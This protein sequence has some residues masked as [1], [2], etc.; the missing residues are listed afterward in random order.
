MPIYPF[1]CTACEYP[2]E[3]LAE[4]KD[5]NKEKYCPHCGS[6]MRRAMEEQT[7]HMRGDIEA[8]F[9]ESLGEYV[10]SRRELREKLAYANAYCPDLMHGSEP[11]AG[12]LTSEERAIEENRSAQPKKTIFERRQEPGWDEVGVMRDDMLEVEGKADYKAFMSEVKERNAARG[13]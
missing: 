10:G 9:D 7:V 2:E 6:L 5:R 12:R 3:V 13:S 4:R 8:G 1:I 11:S